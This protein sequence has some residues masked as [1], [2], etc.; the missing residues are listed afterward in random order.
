M[1]PALVAVVRNTSIAAGSRILMTD[2]EIVKTIQELRDDIEK[3]SDPGK[4]LTKGEKRRKH[5][6]K[7]K[8]EN[9]LLVK[10]AREKDNVSMEMKHMINY[11]L[12]ENMTEKHPILAFFLRAKF[13]MNIFD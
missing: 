10:E 9:L 1:I 3:M 13:R 5:I 6:L 11:G 8:E 7:Q 2:E 4:T 12:L